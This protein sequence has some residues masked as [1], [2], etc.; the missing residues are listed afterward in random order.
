MANRVTKAIQE[1]APLP[2]LADLP[3]SF[4]DNPHLH[5]ILNAY[6]GGLSI[7]ATARKFELEVPY[8]KAIVHHFLS[9]FS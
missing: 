7:T 6:C 9:R 3:E 8:V 2:S 5:R 4:F 1:D